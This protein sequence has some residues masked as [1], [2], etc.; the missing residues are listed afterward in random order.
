MEQN[1]VSL[2]SHV[3]TVLSVKGRHDPCIVPRAVSCIEAV[4]AI[5][6]ADFLI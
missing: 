5:V 3:N 1:S 2:S 6:L 4:T